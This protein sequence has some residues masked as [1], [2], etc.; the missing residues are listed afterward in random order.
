M[1][2]MTDDNL[3]FLPDA[4]EDALESSVVVDADLKKEQLQARASAKANELLDENEVLVNV[5]LGRSEPHGNGGVQ[6]LQHFK[7]W[8]RDGP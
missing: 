5:E 2:T 1:R 6:R 4:P 3:T 7:F 8:K